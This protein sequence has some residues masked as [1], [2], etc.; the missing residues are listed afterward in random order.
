MGALLL[1]L[2]YTANIPCS[3]ACEGFRMFRSPLVR[4][5]I[6][7]LARDFAFQ[8]F[9]GPPAAGGLGFNELKSCALVEMREQ[10]SCDAK[11][12]LMNALASGRAAIEELTNEVRQT[13]KCR[14]RY[15]G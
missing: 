11:D 13:A 9:E 1:D 5:R 7:D 6:L 14:R 4:E 12:P 3:T 10:V 2:P 8:P 15:A